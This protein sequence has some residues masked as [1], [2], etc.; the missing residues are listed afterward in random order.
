M[1]DWWS[2]LDENSKVGWKIIGGF[3]GL[4]IVAVIL[5]LIF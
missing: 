4:M 5:S 3:V 2:G 1:K